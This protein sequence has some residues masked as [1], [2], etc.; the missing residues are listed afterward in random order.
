M[1]IIDELGQQNCC[2]HDDLPVR[3]VQHSA[4]AVDEHQPER[5]QAVV[6]TQDEPLDKSRSGNRHQ[7]SPRKTGRSRSARVSRSAVA[8]SNRTSPRSRKKA[9]AAR[10]K[11]KLALCSTS[12]TVVPSSLTCRTTV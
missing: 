10:L 7:P 2:G 11:A 4:G 6:Q 5:E 3:E 12:R 1:E 9:C 8:P